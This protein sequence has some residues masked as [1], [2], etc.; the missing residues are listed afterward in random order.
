MNKEDIIKE[1]FKQA[2]Q[3]TYKVISD[4]YK[5]GENKKNNEKIYSVGEIDNI[6]DRNQFKKL[7]AETDSEALKKRFSNKKLLNKNN[8]RNPS[9]RTLY[10]LTEKIRYELLGSEML[11]GISKNF[12]DNY[13]HRLHSLKHE[14]ISKKE[15]TNIIDAFEIYMTN[16]FFN[17]ELSPG[18]KEILKFWEDDFN[19]SIF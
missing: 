9:C 7:R 19:K 5:L 13:K 12:K 8:P 14:K 18:N 4:D 17:V 10:H 11:K 3:S 16:K 1:K 6:N 15:D 2:L